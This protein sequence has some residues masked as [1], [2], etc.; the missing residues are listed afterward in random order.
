MPVY[1]YCCTACGERFDRWFAS[2]SRVPAEIACPACQSTDVRRLLSVPAI[3]ST[4][5][6][7][8]DVAEDEAPPPRREVF[9]RKELEQTL[10]SR[11]QS[12]ES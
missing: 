11:G 9:G 5:E 1:E 3:H 12:L 7:S 4:E 2:I 6:G 10:K 8:A